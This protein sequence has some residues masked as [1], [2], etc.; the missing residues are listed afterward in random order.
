MHPTVF[1]KPQLK[2]RRVN[3]VDQ[4]HVEVEQLAQDEDN[5]QQV[6]IFLIVVERNDDG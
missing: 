1:L 5:V 3:Q 4:Q 6:K 2:M